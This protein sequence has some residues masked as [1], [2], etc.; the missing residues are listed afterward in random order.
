M[1]DA[2][3]SGFLVF[4][5]FATALFQLALVLG[6]PMGEYA[7]GGQSPK[8][9]AQ[10]RFSSAV[11]FLVMLAICGHY[12]AQLGW[13]A[14]LL[15]PDLN[16]IINWVLVGFFTLSAVVNNLTKSEKEKRLWGGVTIAM[17]LSSIIVAV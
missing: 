10:Y 1:L 3:A 4:A 11:S 14:P 8:L 12:I 13:L 17:L 6:A 5:T 7:F 15:E 2:F 16:A 9:P